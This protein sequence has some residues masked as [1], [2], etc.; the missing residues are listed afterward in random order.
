M[1]PA[2]I[3]RY[4]KSIQQAN[5]AGDVELVQR[6]KFDLYETLLQAIAEEAVIDT[7]AAAEL[8]LSSDE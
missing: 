5:E 6:L 2:E 1:T 3:K 8:A 4:L 7:Q